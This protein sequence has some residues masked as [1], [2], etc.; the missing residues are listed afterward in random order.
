[1]IRDP[2]P[3]PNSR[4]TRPMSASRVPADELPRYSI[5]Y[6]A[7]K[8]IIHSP[9][10]GKYVIMKGADKETVEAVID[11]VNALELDMP[12]PESISE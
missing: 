7:D 5:E 12:L 2:G 10:I 4:Y 9:A 8:I 11:C 6:V 1:M 3:T